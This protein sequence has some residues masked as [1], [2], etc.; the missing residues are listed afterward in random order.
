MTLPV[1]FHQ[2]PQKAPGTVGTMAAQSPPRPGLIGH[3]S[4]PTPP[5]PEHRALR[6]SSFTPELQQN[7]PARPARGALASAW[8]QF[9]DFICHRLAKCPRIRSVS[10]GSFVDS[11]GGREPLTGQAE[12]CPRRSKGPP[13]MSGCVAGC[14]F[15]RHLLTAAQAA[16]W[17]HPAA[18]HRHSEHIG[19]LRVSVD[20]KPPDAGGALAPDS[21][22]EGEDRVGEDIASSLGW[23]ASQ[24]E[25]GV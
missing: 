10:T 23:S 15:I 3:S 2:K 1:Q 4:T 22:V 18:S 7:P 13:T 14:H 25:V 12:R 9:M 16:G 11:L 5:L 24:R 17:G 8:A 20:S 19:P 6:G 21:S